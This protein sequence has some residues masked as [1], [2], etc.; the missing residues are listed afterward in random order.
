[1]RPDPLACALRNASLHVRLMLV[2]KALARAGFGEVEILDRRHA[3]QKS[4][5]GGHELVCRSPLGHLTVRMLVKVVD[6]DAKTRMLDELAGAV[7]RCGA[8]MGLL[9][10]LHNVSAS[11][12]AKQA[13]YHPARV[14]TMDGK[15]ISDLMRRSGLA[16]RDGEVDYA[17]LAALEEVSE[18]LLAFMRKERR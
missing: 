10:S 13:A 12:A 7:V 5:D 14:E 9:V 4:R 2:S 1:M 8:D 16:V 18:R 6:Q 3:G 17:Y 15:G 11:I